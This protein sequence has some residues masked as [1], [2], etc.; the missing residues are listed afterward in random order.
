MLSHSGWLCPAYRTWTCSCWVGCMLLVDRSVHTGSGSEIL[1]CSICLAPY[2]N[3]CAKDIP[4]GPNTASTQ[5]WFAFRLCWNPGCGYVPLDEEEPH[6]TSPIYQSSGT[7][8]RSWSIQP[9]H[10]DYS[11]FLVQ[12]SPRAKPEDRV[13]IN[14]VPI[15]C[16]SDLS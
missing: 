12:I 3:R 1:I 16:R 8:W 15:G 5:W 6:W 4:S 10:V 13:V 2:W 11:V 7:C 14:G 9:D